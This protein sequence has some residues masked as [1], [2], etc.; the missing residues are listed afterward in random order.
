[1]ETDLLKLKKIIVE[2]ANK[3]GEG[4]IASAFSILD[5]LWVL[6]D[7]ILK[8]NPA[9]PDN[10]NR[11]RFIL[12]KGHASL[13]LYA[14]LANKGF[15][16]FSEFDNFGKYESILGGHPDRNK[17]PG[18][19]AST[20][21][22]GHGFPMAVGMA[23]GL[24]INKSDNRVYCLVGDGEANEG[25]IWESA[26][27]A[28]HH[29]LSNLCLIIDHNHSTDRA[30]VVCDLTEKFKSFGWESCTIDGHDQEKI[31]NT[32]KNLSQSKPTAII[33]ETIKGQGVKM[34][35]KNPAWHHKFPSDDE[36]NEIMNELS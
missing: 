14:I 23:L 5:I 30:L 15:F 33:A 8:I 25:T 18:V 36:L 32:L 7:K 21:S 9:D 20:G 12:S 26:M 2:S 29:K 1:M 17:I 28:A 11:D 31:Y 3:A 27:L 35:E 13:G 19:E 6:Y 16:P 10:E 4:H 22:L 34:M 24:K